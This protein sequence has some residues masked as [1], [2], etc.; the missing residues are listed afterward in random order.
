[1]NQVRKTKV[2]HR[3]W[4]RPNLE[5]DDQRVIS[6]KTVRE[7]HAEGCRVFAFS[8]SHHGVGKKARTRVL[9][10]E[11]C[12]DEVIGLCVPAML[13]TIV[14]RERRNG[15]LI[16]AYV[17]YA[18]LICQKMVS[19]APLAGLSFWIARTEGTVASVKAWGESEPTLNRRKRI[20]RTIGFRVFRL[21]GESAGCGLVELVLPSQLYRGGC[22][23][24]S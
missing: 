23:P 11:R 13:A 2:L 22:L 17:A 19:E 5:N 12:R 8:V 7:S 14:A 10:N 1:M 4:M 9:V 24:R 20:R 6:Q 21:G 3:I 15:F 16:L 18:P